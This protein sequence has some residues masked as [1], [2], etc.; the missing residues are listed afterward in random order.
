MA[1]FIVNNIH[2]FCDVAGA[3]QT[4]HDAPDASFDGP[5]AKPSDGVLS[6]F[7]GSDDGTQRCPAGLVAVGIN[8]RSGVWLDAVGLICGEPELTPGNPENTGT[9]SS[10]LKTDRPVVKTLGRTKAPPPPGA[11]PAPPR[12]ICDLAREARARNS[13][14]APALEERCRAAGER[15]QTIKKP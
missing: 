8:G 2:L 1:T 5:E 11:T 3:T 14:T 12:S 10:A 6:P 15:S 13:P 9:T 7:I 4:L